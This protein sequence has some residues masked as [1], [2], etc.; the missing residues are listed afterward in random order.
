MVADGPRLTKAFTARAADLV[1]VGLHRT[2]PSS[3]GVTS[4]L[5]AEHPT[6]VVIVYGSARDADLLTTATSGAHGLMLWDPTRGRLGPPSP[7]CT[8]PATPIRSGPRTPRRCSLNRNCRSSGA[9]AMVGRIRKSASSW[10]WPWNTV[11]TH[12]RKPDSKLGAQDRA[13]AVALGIRQCP[14]TEHPP[15]SPSA[16][17][18]GSDGGMPG[19]LV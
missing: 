18:C 5:L 17:G 7:R 19:V 13:H 11:Q 9:S 4:L 12:T 6:A 2:A 10:P 8:A 15:P 1:L 14:N 16:G 3:T